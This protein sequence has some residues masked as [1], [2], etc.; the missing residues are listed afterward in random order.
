MSGNEH[1]SCTILLDDAHSQASNPTS[2]LYRKPVETITAYDALG[3]D[4]ALTQIQLA[5]RQK[6]YVVTCFSY[7]LGEYLIGIKPKI[8][9]TPWYRHGHLTR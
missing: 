8:S 5:L 7:E 6:K 1:S 4:T 9:A 3:L 2:R